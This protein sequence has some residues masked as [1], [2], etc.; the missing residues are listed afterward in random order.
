MIARSDQGQLPIRARGAALPASCSS[1]CAT[2][3]RRTPR[4]P[5]A[6]GLVLHADPLRLEQA[7]GNL[8]DNARRHGGSQI[9]LAAESRDGAVAPPRPRRR[10]GLPGD[11]AAFER[12]TRGDARAAGA[13]PASGWRSS[14]RS[15]A[16]TV[17]TAGA[18]TREGGGADVW[19]ELPR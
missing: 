8:L 4:S 7:L 19:I 15:R 3:T 10:P 12:F 14:R 2:A 13:A 11:L 5:A 18:A 6:D 9:E 1:G 16:P 17:E